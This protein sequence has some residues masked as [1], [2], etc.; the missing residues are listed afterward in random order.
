M[1]KEKYKYLI[2]LLQENIDLHNLN[3]A[4]RTILEKHD[5]LNEALRLHEDTMKNI[6]VDVSNDNR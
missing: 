2:K 6:G 4:Y 5:L 1:K 3:I